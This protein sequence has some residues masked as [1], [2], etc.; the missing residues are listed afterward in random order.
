[1]GLPL[2]PVEE[3][4][5]S[6]ARRRRL[7]WAVASTLIVLIVVAFYET[8][9]RT[10]R[11]RGLDAATSIT[12]SVSWPCPSQFLSSRACGRRT[13]IGAAIRSRNKC[14]YLGSSRSWL[15]HLP[16]QRSSGMARRH[17]KVRR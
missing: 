13:A 11:P 5:R 1:M 6:G 7:V 9:N 10:S 16:N 2:P 17:P 3:T 15:S 14:W 8:R 12:H 4:R